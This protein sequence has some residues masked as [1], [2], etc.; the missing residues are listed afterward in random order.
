MDMTAGIQA[1]STRA[2]AGSGSLD[3]LAVETGLVLTGLPLLLAVLVCAGL[4][5]DLTLV[6]IALP[7]G[8]ALVAAIGFSAPPRLRLSPAAFLIAIAVIAGAIFLG[9]LLLDASYDGN[10][11]RRHAP[12][13]L[14]EGWNPLRGELCDR[15]WT[16]D[17]PMMSWVFS[18]AQWTFSG[19]GAAAMALNLIL[20]IGAGLLSAYLLRDTFGLSRRAAAGLAVLLVGNPVVA[21][22]VWT[23][24]VDGL[25]YL[26]CALGILALARLAARPAD[27]FDPLPHAILALSIAAMPALKFTGAVFGAIL[28]V[29][30]LGLLLRASQPPARAWRPLFLLYGIIGAGAALVCFH[31]YATNLLAGEHIFHPVMGANTAEFVDDLMPACVEGTPRLLR[32]FHAMLYA[33]NLTLETCAAGQPLQPFGGQGGLSL[34]GGYA[35]NWLLAGFGGLMPVSLIL[36]AGAIGL[37]RVQPAARRDATVNRALLVVVGLPLLFAML[38]GP[39]WWARY[40]PFIWL[41]VPAGLLALVGL[42][43]RLVRPMGYLVVFAGALPL[44]V[45]AIFVTYYAI[46]FTRH[47][48]SVESVLLSP[49]TTVADPHAARF[50]RSYHERLVR[51]GWGDIAI[52]DAAP[53]CPAGGFVITPMP[54]H[55]I[56]DDPAGPPGSLAALLARPDR[57]FLLVAGNEAESVLTRADRSALAALGVSA[58]DLEAGRMIVPGAGIPAIRLGDAT[59]KPLL[60]GDRVRVGGVDFAFA[61]KGLTVLSFAAD[62]RYLASAHFT[63]DPTEEVC[64]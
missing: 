16:N 36:L 49:Q 27:R 8:L 22:Q 9:S 24:Y 45:S 4:V 52:A 30:A 47:A 58:A 11:Y 60:L 20:I 40:I 41:L 64:L 38:I 31:P 14:M 17:Y 57:Q 25:V 5:L 46:G 44:V 33:G 50:I 10:S 42:R 43:G 28:L 2:R 54:F 39:N 55:L 35:G 3:R 26:Y 32:P 48:W 15:I 61:R 53:R 6:S 18:A 29:L 63:P 21:S 37:R 1:I 59:R 23:A 62:G 7:A 19:S 56:S 13:C 51:Y 34:E 12:A